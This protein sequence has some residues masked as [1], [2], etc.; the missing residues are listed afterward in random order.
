MGGSLQYITEVPV[1]PKCF[2]AVFRQQT[3]FSP[4]PSIH[5]AIGDGGQGWGNAVL[6]IFASS[7]I[8][9]RLFCDPCKSCMKMSGRK[10]QTLGGK[11]T[12]VGER[13]VTVGVVHLEE[14]RSSSLSESGGVNDAEQQHQ[15]KRQRSGRVSNRAESSEHAEPSEVSEPAP[16]VPISVVPGCATIISSSEELTSN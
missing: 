15:I 13:L 3:I 4:L 12:T 8:R 10:L 11:L 6:Y 7:Q 2:T 1:V 5:Q 16:P 9:K 14:S